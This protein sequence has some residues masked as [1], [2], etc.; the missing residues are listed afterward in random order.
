MPTSHTVHQTSDGLIL[1]TG[2]PTYSISGAVFLGITLSD[3][4]LLFGLVAGFLNVC[5]VLT[6]YYDRFFKKQTNKNNKEGNSNENN[7]T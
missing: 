7:C 4:V 3:W 5:L 2:V 6:K 1:A